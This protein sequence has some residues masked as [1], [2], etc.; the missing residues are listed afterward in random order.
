MAPT[1]SDLELAIAG[2][3]QTK[4]RQRVVAEALR[5]T[6]EGTSKAV[7]GGGHFNPVVNLLAEGLYDAVC[8]VV[9]SPADPGPREPS[10]RLDWRHF[11]AAI[12]ARLAYLSGLG[13]P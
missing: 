4:D 13:Y 10:P 2:Y 6:S 8:Y 12:A 5:S 11:S 9:S 1:H 3:W 7:R